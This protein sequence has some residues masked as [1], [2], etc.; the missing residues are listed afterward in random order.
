MQRSATRSA[1]AGTGELRARGV[2]DLPLNS[3][4]TIPQLGFGVFK[5]DPA[6]TADAVAEALKIGYRHIDTAEMYG[7]E[8]EV[9]MRFALRAWIAA[10]F[11]SR[12]SSTTGTTGRTMRAEHS[13]APSRHW[14][15]TTLTSS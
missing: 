11:S 6:E 13:T 1:Q 14:A 7:N 2:P 15:R 4:Q 8:K 3:G 10:K 5:I 9:G 12:A